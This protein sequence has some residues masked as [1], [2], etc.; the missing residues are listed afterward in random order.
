MF[1]R[2]AVAEVM[3]ALRADG[4]E[5]EVE[6]EGTMF[7]RL[8]ITDP[9]GGDVSTVPDLNATSADGNATNADRWIRSAL[10]TSG[11]GRCSPRYVTSG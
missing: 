6:R 5:V 9:V 3:A 8:L 7:I 10:G 11:T 4:L 2:S 1:M